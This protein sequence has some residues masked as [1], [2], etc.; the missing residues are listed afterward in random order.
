MLLKFLK[1][2]HTD[3]DDC[4]KLDSSPAIMEE[5]AQRIWEQQPDE[6]DAMVERLLESDE[7]HLIAKYLVLRKPVDATRQIV[8]LDKLAE[9]NLE[10][11]ITGIL[12]A[13]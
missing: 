11:I 8:Q 4:I 6:V 1:E 2:H 3:G 9:K 5:T 12:R 10:E 7:M 13:E